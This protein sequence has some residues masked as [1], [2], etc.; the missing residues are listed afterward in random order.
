MLMAPL[1]QLL[2]GGLVP[3]GNNF[4]GGSNN[5]IYDTYLGIV[6]ALGVLLLFG[7]F[8]QNFFVKDDSKVWDHIA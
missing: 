4:N 8:T 2:I 1:N 7:C 3:M 5:T 6:M